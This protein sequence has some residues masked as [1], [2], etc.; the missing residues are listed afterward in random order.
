MEIAVR[1]FTS[2]VAGN[3]TIELVNTYTAAGANDFAID[4]ISFVTGC[5]RDTDGDGTP[6]QFDT[7]S[8]GDGCPD[9]IE[10]DLTL[11]LSI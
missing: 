1:R 7:D 5:N 11:L 2:T 8:D 9:A 10:E 6:D 3:Y 4:D